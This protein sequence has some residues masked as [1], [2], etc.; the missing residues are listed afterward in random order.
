MAKTITLSKLQNLV[1][2]LRKEGEN[3]K[4]EASFTLSGDMD[5]HKVVDCTTFLP[6]TFLTTL[7]QRFDQLKDTIVKR[8]LG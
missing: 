5:I 2:T 6:A 4:V 7:S 1:V 3:I 8:E